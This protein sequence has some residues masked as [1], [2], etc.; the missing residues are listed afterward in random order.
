[1]AYDSD[2]LEVPLLSG[3]L[4]GIGGRIKHCPEDFVVEEIPLYPASGEGEHIYVSLTRKGLATR[5]LQQQLASLFGL[6]PAQVG[7]AGQKDTD[8]VSTQTFSLHLPKADLEH[9]E[10][11]IRETLPVEVQW[12]ER[13]LNKLRTGHLKGNTFRIRVRDVVPDAQARAQPIAEILRGKG[14][15]NFYGPQRF[16][17]QGSNIER[18]RRLLVG[19]ARARG[20]ERKFLLSAYQSFLFN[21]WLALRIRDGLYESLLEGDVAKKTDTGGMFVV[22]DL[23]CES[24]RME[25]GAIVYTG[26]IFGFKMRAAQG[27]EQEREER[28]LNEYGIR[29]EMLRQAGL[30]GSR[31]EGTIR[32]DD[33]ALT[34]QGQDL[35]LEFSLPSG[36]YAT[37]VLREFMQQDPPDDG[38]APA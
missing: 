7:V 21:A 25:E 12:V 14:L 27:R 24:A 16:G 17:P 11:A 19:E 2:T 9:V 6:S 3:G 36:S 38:A 31:R 30:E 29:P 4:P 32:L 33:L 22:E 8:A 10:R 15:P 23:A 34:P 18:G 1:M 37:V 26:P 13:H 5:T 28:L 35:L 20:W